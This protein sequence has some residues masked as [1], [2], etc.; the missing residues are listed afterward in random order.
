MSYAGDL[1]VR[2]CWDLLGSDKD[3]FMVDVR[4]VAEWSYVGLPDLDQDMQKIVL[5]QW[6]VFPDMMIDGEF[7]DNLLQQL[8][9]AGADTSSKLCF[10]CRSGVRSLAAAKAMTAIGYTNSYNIT[11]GFEGDL[12]EQGHRGDRNGWKADGLPWRQR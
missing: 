3:A 11:G 5:Q 1:S 10:L 12:N 7:T 2:Q 4:T 8:N 6:Q 9:Q